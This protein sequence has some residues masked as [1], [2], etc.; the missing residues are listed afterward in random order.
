MTALCFQS[1][2]WSGIV[3]C[4]KPKKLHHTEA[5]NIMAFYSIE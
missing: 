4:N 5:Q 1:Q 2:N 3:S